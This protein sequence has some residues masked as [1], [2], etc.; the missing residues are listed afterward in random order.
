MDVPVKLEPVEEFQLDVNF[1]EMKFCVLC[2]NTISDRSYRSLSSNT[3]QEQYKAVFK[4]MRIPGI[5]GFACNI[6]INKFNRVLK[7]NK[8]LETKIIKI[9]NERDKL[10]STLIEM[11]GV[12]FLERQ[13]HERPPQPE[14]LLA[15]VPELEKIKECLIV[16]P[17]SS[18]NGMLSPFPELG[19]T[20][21]GSSN[22]PIPELVTNFKENSLVRP[23]SSSIGMCTPI[24]PLGTNV[25]VL[26]IPAS[27]IIPIVEPSHCP[28]VQKVDKITQTKDHTEEFEVK[29]IVKYKGI[30]RLKIIKEEHEQAA[31]KSMLNNAS[32]KAVIKNF[33]QKENCRKEMLDIVNN[34]ITNEIKEISKNNCELFKEHVSNSEKLTFDWERK[35][36]LL[37]QKAPYLLSVFSNA[38]CLREKQQNLPQ[39]LTALAVLLYGRSQ[40]MNQL[41]YILGF[42]LQKRGLNRESL[43]FFHDLGISVSHAS[44]QRKTKEL[45]KQQEHR[46]Q[47][48]LSTCIEEVKCPQS[49]EKAAEEQTAT[50]TDKR[51]RPMELLVN[52]FGKRTRDIKSVGLS[53]K[54]K[55][56]DKVEAKSRTTEKDEHGR[57]R[58]ETP[59]PSEADRIVE[60][61]N[62][63]DKN[64]LVMESD[65]CAFNG[66]NCEMQHQ[67]VKSEND[68]ELSSHDVCDGGY[69]SNLSGETNPDIGLDME[70][71][72]EP[73]EHL[74]NHGNS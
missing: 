23:V 41:Q 46:F 42:N 53:K 54:R 19:K 36:Q 63:E 17:V 10:I 2:Q 43:N 51:F 13:V 70:V 18:S 8:D 58:I 32:T 38:I 50:K 22:I 72:S 14:R 66:V 28:S 1:K 35:S 5:S 15:P 16:E 74:S 26:V 3:S 45:G 37:Q 39:M 33:S 25:G 30:E 65:S 48:Q 56:C 12:R 47:S 20:K 34:V 71:T 64:N 61:L 4:L 59:K 60:T 55:I 67:Q 68:S 62:E 44:L 31:I 40:N 6:C 21:E 24:P 69:C 9:R 52:N 73:E 57:N 49:V 29:V 27:P 11:P 7:L